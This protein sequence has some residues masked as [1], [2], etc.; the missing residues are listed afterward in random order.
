MVRDIGK[1]DFDGILRESEK[2]VVVDF[3]TQSC[4]YCKKLKPV[5]EEIA[6]EYADEIDVYYADADERGDLAERYEIMTVPAVFVFRDG[7][8]AGNAV[9]PRTK[10]AVIDLIFT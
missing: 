7:K 9:N 1:Q 3:I 8:A 10:E 5:I 6:D 2:P 4:P